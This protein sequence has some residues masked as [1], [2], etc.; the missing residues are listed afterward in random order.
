[1]VIQA[2]HIYSDDFSSDAQA[3][4]A[5]RCLARSWNTRGDTDANPSPHG[6][7]IWRLRAPEAMAELLYLVQVHV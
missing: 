3:T 2:K 5:R 4:I 6:N 7:Q 1:M